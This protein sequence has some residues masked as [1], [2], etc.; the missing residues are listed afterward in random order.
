MNCG[1]GKT[2]LV[3]RKAMLT[4]ILE[5]HIGTHIRTH[6][7]YRQDVFGGAKGHVDELPEE[8]THLFLLDQLRVVFVQQLEEEGN[9]GARLR[10]QDDV[11]ALCPLLRA[12]GT[13]VVNINHSEKVRGQ[14]WDNAV[15][16]FGYYLE[17]QLLH[18]VLRKFR[19]QGRTRIGR[20]DGQIWSKLGQI[21]HADPVH[22]LL[23][24]YR[25]AD[26]C[27]IDLGTVPN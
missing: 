12:D 1:T 13:I 24:D 15:D 19:Q 14:I 7:R 11:L 3:V 20:R 17:V 2:F 8:A 21:L 18:L 26:P 25:R 16:D 27:D 9:N 23:E 5:T 6:L 22:E 10:F 4:S